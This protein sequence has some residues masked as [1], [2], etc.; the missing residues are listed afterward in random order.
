[1]ITGGAG[2]I[3]GHTLRRVREE[4][5]GIQIHFFDNFSPGYRKNVPVGIELIKGGGCDLDTLNELLL[6]SHDG[7]IH[8]AVDSRVLPSLKAPTA[9]CRLSDL[10][11]NWDIVPKLMGK[12]NV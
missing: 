8:L 6:D 3:G 5:P 12:G 9:S 7:V 4:Y 11:R 1:M 2:F 10:L